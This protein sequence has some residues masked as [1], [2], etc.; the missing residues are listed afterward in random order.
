MAPEQLST[1]VW[2]NASRIYNYNSGILVS[3]RHA[4]LIDPGITPEEVQSIQRFCT[5]QDWQIEAIILTHFHY[6][7]VIGA[8]AF[9]DAILITHNLFQR[10]YD[11]MR[12][13]SEEKIKRM[14]IQESMALPTWSLDI[15]PDWIIGRKQ[16]FLLGDLAVDL[17]PI[18]GHTADQIGVYIPEEKFLWAADTLSDLEIPFMSDSPS[19][20]QRSLEKLARLDVVRIVPGHGNPSSNQSEAAGRIRQDLQYIREVRRWVKRGIQQNA[21]LEQILQRCSSMD[22]PNREDNQVPHQ[23]NVEMVYLEEGGKNYTG[24][25][26]W[27]KEWKGEDES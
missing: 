2:R 10:E 4:W 9:T 5:L 27:K 17:I 24:E 18:P 12:M 1:H 14:A 6:D 13:V 16:T 23:W 20:Y 7:H 22:F 25:I 15:H 8:N 11:A 19:Q 21:P 26:G 3:D